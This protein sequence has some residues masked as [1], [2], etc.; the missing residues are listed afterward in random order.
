MEG[1]QQLWSK[2]KISCCRICAR[3]EVFRSGLADF[4]EEI[5][6]QNANFDYFNIYLVNL[7]RDD[8]SIPVEYIQSFRYIYGIKYY[9]QY[10]T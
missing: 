6:I 9:I 4:G 8:E 3:P 5:D 7:N 1:C 10:P 2:V